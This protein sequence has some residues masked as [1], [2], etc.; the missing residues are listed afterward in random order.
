MSPNAAT[1]LNTALSLSED[2]RFAI[3]EALFQSLPEDIDELDDA[4][5]EQELL[6]R[7]EEMKKDPSSGIPWSEL[8]KFR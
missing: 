2:E 1:L 6:R 3:A 5:F 4:A 8:K 7:S